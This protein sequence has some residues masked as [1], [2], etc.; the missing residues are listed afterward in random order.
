MWKLNKQ[1][2]FSA[3]FTAKFFTLYEDARDIMCDDPR[4]DWVISCRPNNRRVEVVDICGIAVFCKDVTAEEGNA[5]YLEMKPLDRYG[6]G[7]AE[8]YAWL[9]DHGANI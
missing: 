8:C 9:R 7:A 5:M 2:P 3:S 6:Y 1:I 4:P